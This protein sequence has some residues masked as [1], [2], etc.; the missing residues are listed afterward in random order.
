MKDDT[1]AE[2]P[3][4]KPKPKAAAPKRIALE[5]PKM[6]GK[7]HVWEKD[8]AAWLGKGWRHVTAVPAVKKSAGNAE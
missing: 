4:E 2:A 7:A 8:I 5:H 3:K 6:K 1:K